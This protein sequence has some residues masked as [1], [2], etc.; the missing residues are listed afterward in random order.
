MLAKRI[1]PCLDINRERVVKGINFKN[2]KDIGNPLELARYYS[3]SGADEIS[4]L[5]ITASYENRKIIL[6]LVKSVANEVFIPLSVGGGIRTIEEIQSILAAGAEKVSI[7]TS[8][9]QNPQLIAKAANKFGNQ[10]I[11]LSI[12]VQRSSSMK[13]GWEVYINGG[14]KPTG[15]DALEFA[16]KMENLGSGEILLNSIDR[17]GTR[18][19]Y[20]LELIKLFNENLK[21]PI[22]AS[23][24]AGTLENILD[25]FTIGGAD[26]ALVASLFHY[27]NYKITEVKKYLRKHKVEVRL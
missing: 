27:K 26:A 7:G 17:D 13:N 16:Q 1:I 14:R 24:G 18:L 5:D 2:L 25:V 3:N 10:A 9:V 20:D 11:V 8:A 22:I 15:L 19:G 21:V 12:D 6:E 23:G 4:F